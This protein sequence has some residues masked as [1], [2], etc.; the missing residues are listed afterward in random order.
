MADLA[1]I[2]RNVAKMVS[3][4]APEA[5]IDG[6]IASEGVTVDDVRNYGKDYTLGRLGTIDRGITFGLGR[7]AG[8]LINAAGSKLA[9]AGIR[10]GEIVA[11]V[12]NKG[13]SGAFDEVE[14]KPSFMERYHEIVDP[15]M[16]AIEQYHEDKPV[17]AF[18]LEM[19]AGFANPVNKVG[20]NYIKDAKNLAGT[21]VRS[22]IVGTGVGGVAG[23]MNTENADDLAVN[24]LGGAGTG[25]VIGAAMPVAANRA[26]ALYNGLKRIVAPEASVAGKATGLGNIVK[27]N[28]SVRALNRGIMADDAVAAQVLQEAPTEMGRLNEELTDI[29]NKT[30]GRKLN[31]EGAKQNADEAYKSYVAANADYPLYTTEDPVKEVSPFELL[32][33]SRAYNK[34]DKQTKSEQGKSLLAFLKSIG[35]IKNTGGELTGRDLHI[36]YPGLVN[37]KGL[38][39]DDAALY[40]WEHGY[41]PGE[42]DY[43]GEIGRPSINKLLDAIDDEMHGIKK[44]SEQ[45]ASNA[46]AGLKNQ[47]D[48]V[49]QLAEEMDML[50][51]DYSK[52]TA[53]EAENA[54][55]NAVSEWSRENSEIP[56]YPFEEDKVTRKLGTPYI[57][58][59]LGRLNKYKQNA[60]NKALAEGASMSD[61]GAGSLDAVHKAQ[62]VLNDMIENSFDKSVLG[63]KRPTTQTSELMSLKQVFNN[64]LEP[65]GVKPLDARIAKAKSLEYFRDMGY[66]FKPSET[67]FEDL[68]IKTLRDKR[69]FLQGRLQAILDNVKDDKNLAKAI[70]AD[71]NTLKKLMPAKKFNELLNET[72][73]IDR[74]YTRLNKFAKLAS[75]E[76]DKPIAADRPMSERS[77][78]MTS[79][80][81]SLYD[82]AN[83]RLWQNSNRRRAQALLNGGAVNPEWVQTLENYGAQYSPRYLTPYLAQIIAQNQ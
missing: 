70:R 64:M 24:T 23:A 63:V 11:N 37:N 71:E 43:S 83:A 17:E 79:Y 12:Q 35:G 19:G 51:I 42:P 32:V 62:G 78:S 76:L 45:E 66:K 53:K 67:K 10:L 39:L 55:N 38:T 27:D 25:A 48:R 1:R 13:L 33:N 34:L 80:L 44:F 7:K 26:G 14:K 74:E 6:Y 5:D 59:V 31:I 61:Y 29:L 52:M 73:R 69:A 8:G 58:D 68:G 15:T 3:M 49:D 28:E 75:R 60:M 4:N 57:G 22:G 16:Q 40:A 77:E 56:V 20:V 65:S 47:Q 36:G 2:K 18:A 46:F 81:G 21:A 54:Y 72:S 9:D 30:T 82:K 41:L 50:G